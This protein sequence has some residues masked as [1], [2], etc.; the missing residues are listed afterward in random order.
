MIHKSAAKQKG[1]DVCFNIKNKWCSVTPVESQRGSLMLKTLLFLCKPF[2]SLWE[3]TSIIFASVYI[4][5]QAKANG[6]PC[7]LSGQIIKM[8]TKHPDSAVFIQGNWRNEF[9]PNIGE[10]TKHRGASY[11]TIEHSFLSFSN[12]LQGCYLRPRWFQQTNAEGRQAY[13]NSESRPKTQS[14]SAETPSSL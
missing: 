13:L 11:S 6:M 5:P 1:G 8:K 14:E 4:P 2:C 7:L 9:P 12:A 3:F 10:N